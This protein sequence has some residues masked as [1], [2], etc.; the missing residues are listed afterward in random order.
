MYNLVTPETINNFS[1]YNEHYD[2]RPFIESLQ[3]IISR[4]VIA[5]RMNLVQITYWEQGNAFSWNLVFIPKEDE[6]SQFG[7]VYRK[8]FYK[9]TER[10]DPEL[11]TCIYNRDSIFTFLITGYKG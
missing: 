5:N 9:I 3:E 7:Q 11:R 1:S 10:L 8:A 4:T 2:F 6:P